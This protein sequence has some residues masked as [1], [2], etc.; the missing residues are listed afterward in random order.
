MTNALTTATAMHS[1]SEPKQRIV[2]DRKQLLALLALQSP[3]TLHFGEHPAA[4]LTTA[5]TVDV[6][7][8]ADV[9]RSYNQG[10]VLV[11]WH[12]DAHDDVFFPHL[13]NCGSHGITGK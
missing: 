5:V 7:T 9:K 12:G 6:A 10:P 1:P 4:R 13:A 3:L 8:E 11:T 2:R